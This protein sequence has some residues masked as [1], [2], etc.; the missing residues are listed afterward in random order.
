MLNAVEVRQFRRI[1]ARTIVLPLLV[2]LLLTGGL[3]AQTQVLLSAT[4]WVD[5]TDRVIAKANEVQRLLIDLETGVRGYL[6]TG[7]ASFLE[8]YTDAQRSIDAA[9]A[10]LAQLVQDNPAQEQQ[11]RG[12]R[13][14][15]GAWYGDAQALLALHD[16]GGAYQAVE[17]NLRGKQLMDTLRGHLAAFI[18]T[19]QD[20]RDTR[21]RAVQGT[22]RLMISGGIVVLVVLGG[23]LAFVSRRQVLLVAQTY[24]DALAAVQAQAVALQASEER[25]RVTLASLGDAVIA[26]DVEGQVTFLNSIAEALTG[27]S[28]ADAAGQAITAVFRIVNEYT[29]QTVE[30]PVTRTLREGRIVGLA[31]HTLLIARDGKECPIDDSSAPIR[32]GAG[33]LI[34]AV[35]VFRDSSAKK[36][37]EEALRRTE[38]RLLVA[39]RGSAITVYAQDTDLRYTWMYN[40]APGYDASQTIGKFD[41]DITTPEDAARL[42]ALKRQVLETGSGVR[43]EIRAT[44]ITGELY[45]DLSIEPMRDTQ[46]RIMGVTGAAHDVTARKQAEEER[47]RLLASEQAARAEAQEAVRMRD[48]FFS[49][50]A[51][52]LK[53]PLTSLVGNIQLIQRR[54][55]REGI[56]TERDER[57]FT[58]VGAQAQRLNTM[59]GALLDVSRLETGQLSLDRT[60]IDLRQLVQQVVAEVQPTLTQHTIA[61]EA[62]EHALMVAGDALRL[63]QVLQNLIQNAVKYSPGGGAVRVRARLQDAA[64]CIEV[65][66]QGIGIPAEAQARLFTRFY[67]ASNVEEQ[68]ISGLGIGL[69]V[70]KEIVT[71]HG[72]TIA[73]ASAEGAGSTFTVRLPLSEQAS[74]P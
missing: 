63:E 57:A 24:Q 60:A 53:T 19:E 10:E 6:L 40:P 22:A 12:I 50:A 32:D 16:A 55:A 70:V 3:L 35:L 56:L 30:N 33:A 31:N 67:R 15:Y 66:D 28:S 59:I 72:G 47:V 14:D 8:P 4:G 26:T 42:T 44:G 49:V 74:W 71:L 48:V 73:V 58:V 34:G 20:L 45:F 37:A 2:M 9:L 64:A 51:H 13:D 1:I 11:L 21:S 41:A 29:R 23:L 38:E 69:Y 62:P 17:A 7:N 39:L 52:E 43:A 27:W 68:Q 46:G 25:F 18:S 36:Q 54:A 5:H 65:I 61:Y